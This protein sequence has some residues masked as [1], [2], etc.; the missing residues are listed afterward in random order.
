MSVLP[1]PLDAGEQD[2]F[3]GAGVAYDVASVCRRLEDGQWIEAGLHTV[4]AGSGAAAAVLDPVGSLGA[5]VAGWMMEH[6]KPLRDLLD[7]VAGDP[8]AVM[9]SAGRLLDAGERVESVSAL[10]VPD[11]ARHLEELD[12]RSVDACRAF[13]VDAA[14][15]AETVARLVRACGEAVRLASGVVDGVRCFIRDAI[16]ELCG[17]AT[18]AGVATVATGG[19]GALVTAPGVV[20]RA[21]A[22]IDRASELTRSLVRSV[23]AFRELLGRAQWMVRV[24]A[25]AT[26]SRRPLSVP[27]PTTAH[28]LRVWG[29]DVV[30][31]VRTASAGAGGHAAQAAASGWLRY[32]DGPS[33]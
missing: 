9:A 4:L 5:G 33:E 8:A 11:T 27:A 14:A 25:R 2:P 15:S 19:L 6:L 23:E 17:M 29:D 10:L 32:R 7:D 13:S 16:A 22:L 20:T 31:R 3:A 30:D 26:R 28:P 18:T 12:G 24:L 1:A 21:S